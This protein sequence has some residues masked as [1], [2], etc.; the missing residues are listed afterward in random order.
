[1]AARVD[2]AI[3]RF[4]LFLIVVVCL[5]ADRLPKKH[6]S[7]PIDRATAYAAAAVIAAVGVVGRLID[8]LSN[9]ERVRGDSARL[10]TD[11]R[12]VRL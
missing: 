3:D 5:A 2:S 11:V 6:S 7:R 4:G 8:R 1:M 9:V 12:G 10:R